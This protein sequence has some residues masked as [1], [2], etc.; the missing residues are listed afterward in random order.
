MSEQTLDQVAVLD[1]KC[2]GGAAMQRLV[3]IFGVVLTLTVLLTGTTSAFVSTLRLDS[4]GSL[5]AS[6]TSA[7]VTGTIVCDAG[8]E[9]ELQVIVLQNSGKVSS[10]AQSGPTITCSGRV[11]AWSATVDVVVG[12][13]FKHGPATALFGATDTTDIPA[14][15][16]SSQTRKIQL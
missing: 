3:M 6:K 10:G 7:T 12:S 2:K 1:H 5:A 8:H 9:V 11:Q 16:F 15:F 13:A 14:T 4:K